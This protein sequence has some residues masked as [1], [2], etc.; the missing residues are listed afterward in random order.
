MIVVA[1]DPG[2]AAA[3]APV[4]ARLRESAGYVCEAWAYRQA[5][6]LWAR[7]GLPFDRCPDRWADADIAARLAGADALLTGTSAPNGEDCEKRAVVLARG[8]GVPSISFVD[9]WSHFGRRF[10]DAHGNLAYLPDRVAVIDEACRD[11]FLALGL[12]AERV[13]VT[14]HPSFD[15]LLDAG[16][17]FSAD[18]RR[19][20]RASAGA[21]D[22]DF[23]VLFASQPENGIEPW[24]S[25]ALLAQALADPASGLGR[26]AML[27]MRPHPKQRGRFAPPA[28]PSALRWSIQE[29]GDPLEAALSADLVCGVA[30]MLL[31]EAAMLGCAVLRIDLGSATGNPVSPLDG[32]PTATRLDELRDALRKTAGECRRF[33]PRAHTH[34]PGGAVAALV[35]SVAKLC[36]PS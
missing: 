16:A 2:G 15:D 28:L 24:R 32:L 17:R 6:E 10:A 20:L 13:V 4:V 11:A 8:I 9:F 34:A 1:G 29:E 35:A 12:A 26:P 33:P 18:D 5:A 30:T 27:A 36:E 21:T 25:L 23:L 19:R 22:R 3:L 31:V 14:G 7:R